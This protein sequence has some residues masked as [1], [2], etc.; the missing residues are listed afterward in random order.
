MSSSHTRSRTRRSRSRS[1]ISVPDSPAPKHLD[2]PDTQDSCAPTQID[3]DSDSDTELPESL[4]PYKH[5]KNLKDRYRLCLEVNFPS[6]HDLLF[7][8]AGPGQDWQTHLDIVVNEGLMLRRVTDFK[9][10][11]TYW[12]HDRWQRPD[13]LALRRM[14]VSLVTE[15]SQLTANAETKFIARYR[16]DPRCRNI[17]KGG[18]SAHHHC[19]PHFLYIVFGSAYQFQLRQQ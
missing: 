4:R 6:T 15:D 13:Y 19:S 16:T 10:G 11:V 8:V 1:V 9:V 3:S 17:A 7:D 18:E 5:W 14:V 12:P 2:R